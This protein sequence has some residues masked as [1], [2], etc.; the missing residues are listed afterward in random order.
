M[1]V[2]EY[3]IA[4]IPGDGEC[5]SQCRAD[6]RGIGIE[7]TASALEVLKATQAK[8]GGYDL[9]VH[10]LDYGSKLPSRFCT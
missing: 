2:R 10:E 1:A 6:K 4:A 5:T 7:V 9:V 3:K 8:I